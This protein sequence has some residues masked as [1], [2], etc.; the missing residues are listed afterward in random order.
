MSL[1]KLY[2]IHEAVA[3]IGY[4]A[5]ANIDLC[6]PYC[7][8]CKINIKSEKA[9][10]NSLYK[11]FMELR[12]KDM[13]NILEIVPDP[14]GD[15]YRMEFDHDPKMLHQMVCAYQLAVAL[16]IQTLISVIKKS[17]AAK[18]KVSNPLPEWID[19]AL[20]SFRCAQ[21]DV[22]ERQLVAIHA[23]QHNS[24]HQNQYLTRSANNE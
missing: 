3:N 1:N 20:D 24:T 11:S 2:E 14:D 10:Y 15:G 18:V 5:M 21:L 17:N 23:D 8:K 13:P 22:Y 6:I 7:E 12:D 9:E 4:K 16:S 19:M